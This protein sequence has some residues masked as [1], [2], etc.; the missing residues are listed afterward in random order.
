MKTDHAVQLRHIEKALA[1]S[2]AGSATPLPVK[3]RMAAVLLHLMER[4]KKFGL[5][6]ILGW[7]ERWKSYADT[8][9]VSQD[10]FAQRGINIMKIPER[11]ARRPR[12]DRG[13]IVNTVNFDGAIL[14]DSRGNVL[15]SGTMIEGLRP[16]ATA[17]KLSPG[18]APDLS[19]HFGFKRKVHMRHITAITSSY[20]FR[21]T[22][23][24]TISE[25]TNDLHIFEGG[26]IIYSSVR[27][28]PIV[29]TK[30][31]VKIVR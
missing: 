21:G 1:K 30:R 14:V 5:F 16:R 11:T 8:P 9:D 6:V 25:E 7:K 12:R 2:H 4:R 20:T 15:H 31:R 26:K 10:L 17:H 29:S 27:G 18:H 19:S 13:N 23:V 24:F 28:E 3:L 22:T